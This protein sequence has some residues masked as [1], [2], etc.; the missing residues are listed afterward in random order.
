MSQYDAIKASNAQYVSERPKGQLPMPPARKAAVVVRA[1][2]PRH[3]LRKRVSCCD[4]RRRASLGP[5]F[6]SD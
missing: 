5:Q 2:E 4:A 3:A 1:M 6:G